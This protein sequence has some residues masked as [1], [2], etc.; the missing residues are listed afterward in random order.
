[1]FNMGMYM[2]KDTG[3]TVIYFFNIVTIASQYSAQLQ[4]YALPYASDQSTWSLP[5]STDLV[6][7]GA[8]AGLTGALAGTTYPNAGSGKNWWCSN[9]LVPNTFNNDV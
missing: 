3:A 4:A 2:T 7:S 5:N 9:G 6:P 1:M 8:I